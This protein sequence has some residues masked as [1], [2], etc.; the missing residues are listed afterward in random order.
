MNENYGYRI[1]LE[2]REQLEAECVPM[3]LKSSDFDEP[4]RIDPRPIVV[5]EDQGSMGSCQGHALSTCLEWCHYIATQGQYLQLSRLF[6]YLGSQKMSNIVGDSGSTLQGGARLAKEHGICP[7]AQYPYPRPVVY[8]RGGYKAIPDNLW[9]AAAPY[10][11]RSAS[12]IEQEPDAKTFLASGA[13]LVEIGI[14][15]GSA[16]TPNSQGI[17]SRFAPGGGGH[18]VV[19]GGYVPDAAVGKSTDQGYYYLLHNSWSKRWGM[20]GWAYVTPNAVRQMLQHRF[21]YFVGL[22]DMSE[23]RP[24]SVDFIKESVIQ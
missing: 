12:W 9:A 14:A 19:I 5:T 22:S 16:M 11:I 21:T 17:I 13:G 8:P 18:A 20:D 24:R 2:D 6:A 7:E 10:K 23:V 15:W 3:A 1:D 4:E